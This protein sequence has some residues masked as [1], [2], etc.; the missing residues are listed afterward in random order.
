MGVAIALL[1]V[2][3]DNWSKGWAERTLVAGD[4]VII[5]GFF[6]L[7]LEE[8]PGAAF[9]IFQNAGP[10]LGSLPSWRQGSSP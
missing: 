1:V 5:P 9:S 4:I 6:S 10:F 7:H 3:L 2:I 8:N